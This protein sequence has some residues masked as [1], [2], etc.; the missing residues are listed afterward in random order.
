[1]TYA[2]FWRIN[3]ISV[4]TLIFIVSLA[5][6]TDDL[7]PA[8]SLTEWLSRIVFGTTDLGDKIAHFLAYAALGFFSVLGWGR[9]ARALT[10][11][12]AFIIVYGLLL[13]ILQLIGGSRT[14]DVLDLLADSLGGLLGMAGAILGVLLLNR[15]LPTPKGRP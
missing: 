3:A 11:T 5:P 12:L 10:T 14:G 15:A 2:A 7:D 6:D 1:M 9:S 8:M 13:E 4:A